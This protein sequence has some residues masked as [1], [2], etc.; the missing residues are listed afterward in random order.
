VSISGTLLE[1][2]EESSY[3][4]GRYAEELRRAPDI[5]RLFSNIAITMLQRKPGSDDMMFELTLRLK[6][7]TP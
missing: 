6:R 1:S 5:G 2:A 4:L 3:T 7:A